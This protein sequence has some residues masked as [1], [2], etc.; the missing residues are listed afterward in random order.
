MSRLLQYLQPS[1][2]DEDTNKFRALNIKLSKEKT[3]YD[4]IIKDTEDKYAIKNDILED[5]NKL[6]KELKKIY[7][8]KLL[9]QLCLTEGESIN[10]IKVNQRIKKRMKKYFIDINEKFTDIKFNLERTI[11]DK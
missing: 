10:K 4:D 9:F 2:L 7:G 11:T 8:G 3:N 5:I 6:N 1:G